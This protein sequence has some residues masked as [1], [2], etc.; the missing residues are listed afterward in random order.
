M[1]YDFLCILGKCQRCFMKKRSRINSENSNTHKL[2]KGAE[3]T[4]SIRQ[5][6]KNPSRAEVFMFSLCY[7]T[8]THYYQQWGMNIITADM[9]LIYFWYSNVS[10]NTCVCCTS[11][12]KRSFVWLLVSLMNLL[13]IWYQTLESKAFV[14]FLM[15]GLIPLTSPNMGLTY[16][17]KKPQP[18]YTPWCST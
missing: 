1:R 12:L 2:Y 15:T 8:R 6:S 11:C 3:T 10:N 14:S 13:W 7:V 18:L 4:F 9:L 16:G 17:H 5:K